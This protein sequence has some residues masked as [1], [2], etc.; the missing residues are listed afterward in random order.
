MWYSTDDSDDS[1]R[2]LIRE[3]IRIT[4][5]N[6]LPYHGREHISWMRE[7]LEE[8]FNHSLRHGL[9]LEPEHR[10]LRTLELLSIA[11][12]WHDTV[13]GAGENEEKSA[14]LL[15]EQLELVDHGLDADERRTLRELI[16]STRYELDT[17]NGLIHQ[18]VHDSYICRLFADADLGMM[19]LDAELHHSAL[20]H[21]AEELGITPSDDEEFLEFLE[22][23]LRVLEQQPLGTM[24]AREL[25]AENRQRNIVTVLGLIEAALGNDS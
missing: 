14:R 23:Q 25:Y 24:V 8:L 20:A 9:P 21:L 11:A 19:G 5:S 15:D 4:E 16:L 10:N 17:E 2:S 1:V 13:Q 22:F 18:K 3:G 6:G 12:A 7:I